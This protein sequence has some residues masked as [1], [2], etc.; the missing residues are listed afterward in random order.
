MN[1]DFYNNNSSTFN[2]LNLNNNN[3]NNN[4]VFNPCFNPCFNPYF[5]HNF[6]HNF[7][8]NYNTDNNPNNNYINNNIIGH[9]FN[10]PLNFEGNLGGKEGNSA[11]EAL[12]EEKKLYNL[13]SEYMSEKGWRIF[14]KDGNV[15]KSKCDSFELFSYLTNILKNNLYLNECIIIDN[16][17]INGKFFQGGKLYVTN[18]MPRML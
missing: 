8:P 5:N 6:N 1:N 9:I 3:L 2:M 10:Q 17:N 16:K 7:I 18:Q 4:P 13:V 14:D 11:E 15:K 12:D